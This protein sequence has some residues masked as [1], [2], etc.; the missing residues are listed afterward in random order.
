MLPSS[1]YKGITI[2][3]FGGLII[4]FVLVALRLP[5]L[6]NADQLLNSDEGLVASQILDLLSGG[7]LFFYYDVG[8]YFGI[9]NGLAAIPFFWI[10]GIGGL[11][12]KLPP[13]LFYALYVLSTYWIVRQVRP[14]AALTVVL[15]MIFPSPLISELTVKNWGVCLICLLGN[16]IFLSFFK[17]KE[18][19]GS[20]VLYTFLLGF[21]VGFAIYTFT[22][23]IVYIGSI[24]ILFVLTNDYWENIRLKFSIKT[25]TS[26]FMEQTGAMRKFVSVLDGVILFFIFTVLFSYVFG[27]FGVDIA[28]YSILQSNELHKPLVQLLFLVFFRM[29]LFRKDIKGKL[30]SIKSLVRSMDPLFKRSVVFCFF[31]FVI[32][33]M[34]RLLSIFSGETT[35][36]GQGFDIDFVPTNLVGHF[37]QLMTD[38]LPKVL[39]LRAPIVQ[40]FDYEITPF[41]LLNAFSIAIIIFLISRAAILFITTRWK[42]IKDIFR[43]K[44]LVFSPV[45]FF[46]VLPILICAA[47]IVSQGALA[48]RYLFPLHGVVSVWIAI[49]LEKIRHESRVFFAVALVVWCVFSTVGIYQAY[50]AS[51]IVRDF[52]IVEKPN[53]YSKVLEF[54]KEHKILY[55]YSDYGLSATGTFLSKGD[56]QIAEYTKDVW[57]KRIK[58]RLAREDDFAVIV[59]NN[60]GGNLEVYQQYLDENL[61]SYSKNIVKDDNG[62]NDLYYVFTNFQGEVKSIDQLRSLIVS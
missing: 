14:Q 43:L 25:V 22:Y 6:I 42:D 57:G 41:Y 17:V 11:A 46:L 32:G 8:R 62:A 60:G 20:N 58:E 38:I 40:L 34:P 59:K 56:V 37:W 10:F 12:F 48:G 1:Q 47:V 30:N 51:G 39:G 35:R 52:S 5:V 3:L 33:I 23:S 2:N 16:L 49:Y 31:G 13:I 45:Q 19:A 61:H 27:G 9:V 18:T 55:A 50:V 21:F 28:G 24:I 44:A 15:L 26:W 4:F 29:C 54:C 36:G 53:R 7:P